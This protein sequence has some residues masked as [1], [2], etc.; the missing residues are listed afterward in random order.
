MFAM[1]RLGFFHHYCSGGNMMWSKAVSQGVGRQIALAS[2]AF[3]A[4]A[5]FCSAQTIKLSVASGPPTT[6]VQVSGSGFGDNTFVDIYFDSTDEALVLTNGT[7]AF[8]KIA[9]AVPAS[10]VP[11][12]HYI[13][14][15][16]RSTDGGAQAA[17]TVSTPWAE[18]GFTTNGK[19][20]NPYENVLNVNNAPGLDYE[21]SYATNSFLLESS[22]AVVNGVVYVGSYDE[23]VY[24]INAATGSKLWSFKTTDNVNSSPTVVNGV[25]YVGSLSFYAL[26]AANGSQIWSFSEGGYTYSSAAVSNG[27]VYFAGGNNNVY[28]VN[29]STG[30]QVWTFATGDLLY[31]APAV[32]NGAVYISSSDGN[33]YALNASTGA[34]IW[35]FTVGTSAM[36]SSAAVSDG[37]VYIGGG[38]NL[39]CLSAATGTELW[40][41][42]TGNTVQSSPAVANGAVYFGSQDNNVYALNATT[43]KLLWTYTT[44]GNV[45][46][47]AAVADGV[48]YFGS[49]DNNVYG[50]NAE[51]GALLWSYTTGNW[52]TDSPTVVNGTVYVG[53]WDTNLYAFDNPVAMVHPPQRP[54]IKT[55]QPDLSLKLSKPVT[56]L[57]DQ[58]NE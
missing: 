26:N 37:R 11:G 17:F 54:D 56:R 8:S 6:N 44:G 51:T 47:S 7:G 36:I 14:A 34:E 50:L 3:L 52:V 24:A 39:Y 57:P 48:V 9:I 28:A 35:S 43:G 55:L 49:M 25:V 23:N 2:I 5:G 27:L 46:S 4:L 32:A 29:A 33:V 58:L 53:S 38:N 10:A 45:E 42:V 30:T 31:T 22:P 40:S 18:V 21:W 12:T 16:Q 19:R 20:N 15:V 13:S 41:F 1:K